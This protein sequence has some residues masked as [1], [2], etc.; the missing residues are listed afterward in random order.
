MPIHAQH[1]RRTGWDVVRGPGV[2][3]WGLCRAIRDRSQRIQSRS[4]PF[5]PGST[6]PYWYSYRLSRVSRGWLGAAG[7]GVHATV[8]LGKNR[9]GTA[10]GSPTH[11]SGVLMAINL[12][13][14]RIFWAYS[15]NG[16]HRSAAPTTHKW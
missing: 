11:A 12:T 14:S 5:V 3:G 7:N 16:T 6:T 1:G 4:R 15:R 8:H 10:H 13:P 9:V 2:A